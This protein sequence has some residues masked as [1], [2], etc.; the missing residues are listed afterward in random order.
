MDEETGNLDYELVEAELIDDLN[1]E[2]QFVYHELANH[3]LSILEECFKRK[4]KHYSKWFT[5]FDD[6]WDYM[7]E[8]VRGKNYTRY[9][10]VFYDFCKKRNDAISYIQKSY[11][12]TDP[13]CIKDAIIPVFIH[14]AT[15]T[16][17]VHGLTRF[18]CVGRKYNDWCNAKTKQRPKST[19][20]YEAITEMDDLA[21]EN[22]LYTQDDDFIQQRLREG[23]NGD[24][25]LST[26]ALICE[27]LFIVEDELH[28]KILFSFLS[29]MNKADDAEELDDAGKLV[30]KQISVKEIYEFVNKESIQYHKTC[31][32]ENRDV[33]L[34]RLAAYFVYRHHEDYYRYS[35]DCVPQV[36]M[37]NI[38]RAGLESC[39]ENGRV[40]NRNKLD[41]IAKKVYL[42]EPPRKKFIDKKPKLDDTKRQ[43]MLHSFCEQNAAEIY[44]GTWMTNSECGAIFRLSVSPFSH[45]RYPDVRRSPV[46]VCA[47]G[48]IIDF[49]KLDVGY[50]E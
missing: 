40:T 17:G 33:V 45:R 21:F 34:K 6:F 29:S 11:H 38:K 46:F 24:E 20:S 35:G 32:R 27:F 18:E 26:R 28:Q 43:E 2:Q 5:D 42:A 23:Q 22:R 47:N 16:H 15:T 31:V 41:E 25:G 10:S 37:L 19:L 48:K 49:A 12:T 1:D 9:Q 4:N 36:L 8:N 14:D 3:A 30:T 50:I 39:L 44:K 7:T 13:T